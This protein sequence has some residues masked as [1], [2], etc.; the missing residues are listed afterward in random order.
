MIK[1]IYKLVLTKMCV[2][3]EQ[4]MILKHHK[5]EDKGLLFL[6]ELV[7]LVEEHMQEYRISRAIF[8]KML[9]CRTIY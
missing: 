6:A 5:V 7:I 4:H 9:K 3:I 8:C 2:T 1:L